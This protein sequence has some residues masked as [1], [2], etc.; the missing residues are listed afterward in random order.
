MQQVI[1]LYDFLLFPFYLVIF[2]LVV[3]KKARK[4]S[5][6]PLRKFFLLA[7]WLHMS[8]AIFIS[9]LMQYYYGYGDSFAYYAGGNVIR[10]MIG[11][12]LSSIKYLF[13]S[14]EDLVSAAEAL[15]YGDQIPIQMTGNANA[16]VMK[17]SGIISYFS[18][19][20]FLVI[21][22]FFGFFSFIGTWKLFYV[23]KELNKRRHIRLL[24]Y[25][26]IC[27]PSLWLWG[28]GLLKEPICIGALGL[29]VFIIYNMLI[30]RQFS[31]KGLLL[32]VLL[33][34]AIT[35][36]KNYIIIIFLVAVS[37]VLIMR[38]FSSIKN[39]VLRIASIILFFC[40]VTIS[41]INIGAD[42]YKDELVDLSYSQIENFKNNYE[43]VQTDDEDNKAGFTIGDINPTF[44]SLLLNSPWVIAS[45]LFRPFIWESRKIIILFAAL[46][47]F[48]I[49]LITLFVFF[50][51]KFLG[52]FYYALNDPYRFFCF[53]FS[54]LFALLIGY[55]TYNFG[56]MIR[57]KI[58]FL[59]FYFFL[60]INIYTIIKLKKDK[61]AVQPQ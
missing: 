55:T 19:N 60:L 7:F 48:L 18:F 38:L 37:L 47:A 28:S 8:G 17:V 61:A 35:I 29:S 59:P 57:Y 10:H 49:L 27:T 26:T 12:N 46:E 43:A 16:F 21:S 9:F 44:S 11:K 42:R 20:S 45:C 56:T 31:L 32:V 24:G 51:T 3:R 41:L 2:Y 30:R 36:V 40:M 4:Y 34:Y 52:F 25:A 33:F 53:I 58:I 39:I 22:L 1:F 5:G 50:K 54:M 6:T 15:G 23:F 14:G 13:Y